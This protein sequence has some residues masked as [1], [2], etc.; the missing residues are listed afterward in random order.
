MHTQ[1][2]TP[3][4]APDA[5]AVLRN[6]TAEQHALLHRIMPL[7]VDTDTID[8]YLDHLGLLR[9]WLVPLDAWL[10]GFDDGPQAHPALPDAHRIALID[11]DFAHASVP[12]ASRRDDATTPAVTR[13]EGARSAAYRWG[14]SYVVE[15]SQLGGSVL[16]ARLNQRLAPHPLGY[17]QAGREQAGA[18]WSAVMKALRSQVQA[19]SHDSSNGE[20]DRGVADALQGASDAF[21]ALIALARQAEPASAD[22]V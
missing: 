5:L 8:D 10:A 17:L 11:A 22:R 2:H 19:A 1:P 15:G 21:D 18:R 12:A 7:S 14:I 3:G 20:P 6:A 9:A 13:W 16:Y 4:A